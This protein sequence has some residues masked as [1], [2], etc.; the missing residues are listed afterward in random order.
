MKPSSEAEEKS[1]RL[2]KLKKI[3]E[4][5]SEEYEVGKKEHLAST[6]ADPLSLMMTVE[7]VCMA[8][9]Y[10]E[11]ERYE[12]NVTSEPDDAD[13]E[14]EDSEDET[15]TN[16]ESTEVEDSEEEEDA[17]TVETINQQAVKIKR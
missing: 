16:T 6:K 12:E 17:L 10:S 2:A 15:T 3:L 4:T 1:E 14:T 11:A 9:E 5:L 13:D 8:R 7:R